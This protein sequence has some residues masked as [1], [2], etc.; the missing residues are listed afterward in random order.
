MQFTPVRRARLHPRAD[1]PP[2]SFL[3]CQVVKTTRPTAG[4]SPRR[5]GL[6]PCVVSTSGRM[7]G[8]TFPSLGRRA[9]SGTHDR[10]CWPPLAISSSVCSGDDA[11]KVNHRVSLEVPPARL[12]R[13]ESYLFDAVCVS[14]RSQRRQRG[15][16][17][18]R[19]MRGPARGRPAASL[20]SLVHPLP[21]LVMES[22]VSGVGTRSDLAVQLRG[23]DAPCRAALLSLS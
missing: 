9:Q 13:F 10:A 5:Q 2:A 1:E 18:T 15:Q 11:G 8:Q 21:A 23:L 4:S 16:L 20:V 19:Q 6:G 7:A 3:P 22:A 14:P 17:P 12:K